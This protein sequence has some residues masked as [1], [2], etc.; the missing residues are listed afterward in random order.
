MSNVIGPG[1][2]VKR[3]VHLLSKSFLIILQAAGAATLA[4][5]IYR[6]WLEPVRADWMLTLTF[7]VLLASRIDLRLPGV[8]SKMTIT[9]TFIYVGVLILNPWAAAL[10]GS[11]DG[12]ATSLRNVK[13][14]A[15]AWPIIGPVKASISSMPRPSFS[16][17]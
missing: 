4:Y 10:L 7:L 15:T 16:I 13:R 8:R 12:L 3:S 9:D 2:S 11:I 17:R 14:L 5:S 6:L 1:V